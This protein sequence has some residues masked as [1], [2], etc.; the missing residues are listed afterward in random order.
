MRYRRRV[1][2]GSESEK[3]EVQEQ[4][5]FR[6]KSRVTSRKLVVGARFNV[7]RKKRKSNYAFKP[8]AGL[9]LRPNRGLAGR[10]GLMRR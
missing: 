5:S 4:R 8:T 1:A 6:S 9:A 3:P 10:G 7:R 2:C